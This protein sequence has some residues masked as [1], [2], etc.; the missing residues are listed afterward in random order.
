[1][2]AGSHLN[3]KVKVAFGSAILTLL[4][5]GMVSY[6]LILVSGESDRWVRHTE[7]VLK[8]LQDLLGAMGS[9][10]SSSSGFALTGKEP[11]LESYRTGIVRA[12][13]D[14]AVIRRLTMDNL[15]Q[16]QRI[17][18]LA[19]LIT[20]KAQFSDRV[21]ALRQKQG[22]E[23]AGD[24]V[25]EGQGQRSMNETEATIREMREEELRLLAFRDV[26]AKRRLD[27]TRIGLIFGTVL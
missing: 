24:A 8:N 14:L 10:D 17:P 25:R 1:M 22:L 12:R 4:I 27:Q 7:E 5:V 19:M 23:A 13:Q 21:I 2:N 15:E 16:Q 3:R 11:Y 6:R 20:Q 18:V 9:I 26:K